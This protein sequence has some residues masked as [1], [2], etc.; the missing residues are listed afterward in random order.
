MSEHKRGRLLAFDYGLKQIGVA[1]GN[2]LL[3]TTEPL[4]ILRA[5]NGQPD[6]N[7]VSA[8]LAEWQPGLLIVGDPLNMDGSISELTKR[9]RRFARRLQGRFGIDTELVDERL[10]SFEV[11]HTQRELGHLGDYRKRPVDSLAAELILTDWLRS[12]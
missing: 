5:S 6:W 12:R 2:D 7:V 10:S 11:K 4:P 8:L 1:V 3:G 9:A